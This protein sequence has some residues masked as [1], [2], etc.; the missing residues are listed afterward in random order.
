MSYHCPAWV[1]T[2]GEVRGAG[3]TDLYDEHRCGGF[4]REQTVWLDAE[5]DEYDWDYHETRCNDHDRR[6]YNDDEYDLGEELGEYDYTICGECNLVWSN[7][8]AIGEGSYNDHM[9]NEHGEARSPSTGS[10]HYNWM[11]VA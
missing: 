1:T 2:I 3:I 8:E 11:R 9:A 4:R 10:I 5:G 7:S 6:V